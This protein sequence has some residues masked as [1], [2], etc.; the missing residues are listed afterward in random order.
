MV[1]VDVMSRVEFEKIPQTN[2][3][4]RSLGSLVFDK[5]NELGDR[6]HLDLTNISSHQVLARDF[7]AALYQ[8]TSPSRIASDLTIWTYVQ[9]I[10]EFLKYVDQK[11]L[12]EQFRM[13]EITYEFLLEYRAH[14]QLTSSGFKSNHPRRHFGNL[15]RLLVAGW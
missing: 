2:N 13:M 6:A 8:H 7:I 15:I 10:K 5:R 12:P 1:Q 9:T 14:I 3:N 11:K 4:I